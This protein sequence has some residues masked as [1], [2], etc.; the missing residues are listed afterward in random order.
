MNRRGPFKQAVEAI[1]NEN[2]DAR[3]HSTDETGKYV[4]TLYRAGRLKNLSA[5]PILIVNFMPKGKPPEAEVLW[6]DDWR[7]NQLN[8]LEQR[9]ADRLDAVV[10]SKR[11]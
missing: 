4:Y 8:T 6:Y 9:I 1:V 3:L 5:S 2:Y 10:R 7:A 11:Q